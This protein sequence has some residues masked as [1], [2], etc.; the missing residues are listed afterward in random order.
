MM[1]KNLKGFFFKSLLF[2]FLIFISIFYLDKLIV[3]WIEFIPIYERNPV[4][5]LYLSILNKISYIPFFIFGISPLLILVSISSFFYFKS[6]KKIY[7]VIFLSAVSIEIGTSIK[8][9]FKFLFSRNNV[10]HFMKT[11]DD[12]FQWL[13]DI[14]SLSAFPSGHTL[15]TVSF[16][17]VLWITYPKFRIFYLFIS[18]SIFLA[19]M[20]LQFHFLSDILAGVLLGWLVGYLVVYLFKFF[21]K[22]PYSDLL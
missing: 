2:V 20:V 3:H 13:K 15:A 5:Q 12:S 6:V 7:L 17:A 16:I 19:L 21:A 9:I 10:S 1:L 14:H 8:S 18:I 11:N 22:K 4:S